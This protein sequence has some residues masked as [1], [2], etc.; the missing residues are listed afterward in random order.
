MP[1]KHIQVEDKVFTKLYRQ[2]GS[3]GPVAALLGCC[4]KTV[5]NRLRRSG[6]RPTGNDRKSPIADSFVG[7]ACGCGAR[8]PNRDEKGNPRSFVTGHNLD[9]IHKERLASR[10]KF[11]CSQC[12]K[13]VERC[14]CEKNKNGRYFCSRSCWSLYAWGTE[15]ER[16]LRAQERAR[17][18]RPKGKWK[19]CPVCEAKFRVTRSRQ[20]KVCCSRSCRDI[21]YV[22]SKAPGWRGGICSLRER[23]VHSECYREWRNAV[24]ARD[25]YRCQ[26]C[27]KR[28]RRLHAHHIDEPFSFLLRKFKIKTVLQA[29]RCRT[30]WSI[31]RGR[32]LCVACHKRTKTYGQA[33][34][35]FKETAA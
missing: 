17:K 27:G 13:A 6:I 1:G 11:K 15:R 29:E 35:Y 24:F 16:I 20:H 12:G 10:L 8:I 21:Y 19:V 3:S 31:D 2:Y 7:C 23:L 33:A 5:R 32:T 25:S 34:R 14:P 22:G 9:Q 30:L 28:S 4:S 18:R 26:E